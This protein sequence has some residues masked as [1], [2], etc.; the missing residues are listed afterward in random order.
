M[1]N[2]HVLESKAI[3]ESIQR[4]AEAAKPTPVKPIGYAVVKK[5]ASPLAEHLTRP[6]KSAID[7]Q[8]LQALREVGLL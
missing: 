5:P 3:A 7:P 4:V 2:K 8:V 1:S 6:V